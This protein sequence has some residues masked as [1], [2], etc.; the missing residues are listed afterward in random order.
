MIHIEALTKSY[1]VGGAPLPILKSLDLHIDEGEFVSIM[2]SSG[3]GKSTL[4]NILGILDDY[5]DGIYT[6]DGRTIRN[7]SERQAAKYRNEFIGFVFQA[8]HLLPF[9]SALENVELPL[10]YRGTSRRERQERAKVLLERVGLGH[11]MDHLPNALSGGERQ[12]VA[13]ARALV[14]DPRLVLADEP[15]GALDTKTSH[16]IMDLLSEINAEGKTVVIVTHEADIAA[17]TNRCIRLRDGI[18][19]EDS[20]NG[21]R[22]R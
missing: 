19:V 4:L 5:N 17:Q 7:L 10:M 12:R 14:G 1:K 20:P 11:R 6:L 18:V 8:F 15:T 13:I 3:S 22:D 21:E 2:G 9:K 16:Q